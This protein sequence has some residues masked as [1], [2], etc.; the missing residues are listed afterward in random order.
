MPLN[1][2]MALASAKGLLASIDSALQ[3]GPID[4]EHM[5]EQHP[6]YIS[7]THRG[8]LSNANMHRFCAIIVLSEAGDLAVHKVCI[9]LHTQKHLHAF[10]RHTG[11]Q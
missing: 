6:F 7:Y 9:G 11:A 3:M 4:T 10:T 2:V 5:D 8:L 1:G